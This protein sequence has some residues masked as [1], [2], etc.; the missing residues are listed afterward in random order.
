MKSFLVILIFSLLVIGCSSK[1]IIRE[2]SQE[3][4]AVTVTGGFSFD[5]LNDMQTK[6]LNQA[7]AHCNIKGMEYVFLSQQVKP[8][9]TATDSVEINVYFRCK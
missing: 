3:T 4:Y 7:Q 5:S 9:R 8:V 1:S 2:Y 6:A